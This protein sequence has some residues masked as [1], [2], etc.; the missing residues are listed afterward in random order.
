MKFIKPEFL[1]NG[2]LV[3]G[4]KPFHSLARI[5]LQHPKF[6]V[7]NIRVHLT[8]KTT[9]LIM[10][11]APDDENSPPERPVGFDPQEAFAQHD[12]TCY[13]QDNVG[14][15]IVKLI[16]VSKD[17]SAEERMQRKRESAEKEGEEK[18]PEARGWSGNDFGPGDENFCWVILQD[19]NLLGAL[20]FL[21]QE[22]GLDLVAH[23]GR[24]GIGGLG[25]LHGGA[26]GGGASLAHGRGA[27]PG[28]HRE[29][30]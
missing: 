4:V 11:R 28:T 30:E 9:G 21:L 6:E 3:L 18:Y 20:Q 19:A 22:L 13:V 29:W 1:T 10:E 16:P 15:Q 25:L 24:V 12:K 27:Q 26:S 8:A 7:L 23:S 5:V 14:I 17:K 2:G